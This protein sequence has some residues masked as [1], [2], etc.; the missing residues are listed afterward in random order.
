MFTAQKTPQKVKITVQRSG[1][2]SKLDE[3][4]VTLDPFTQI[5]SE[6]VEVGTQKFRVVMA[7]ADRIES[8]M[9]IIEVHDANYK[10]QP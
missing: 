5:K 4:G 7:S 8:L 10:G 2:N 6:I 9:N 3:V 1:S